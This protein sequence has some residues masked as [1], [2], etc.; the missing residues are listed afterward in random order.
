MAKDNPTSERAPPS[1]SLP[2][3]EARPDLNYVYHLD[4][5]IATH[6]AYLHRRASEDRVIADLK[7]HRPP[8]HNTHNPRREMLLEGGVQYHKALLRWHQKRLK[9]ELRDGLDPDAIDTWPPQAQ[10]YMEQIDP[11]LSGAHDAVAEAVQ[12]T[13]SE[14]VSELQ[15]AADYQ[16]ALE[17]QAAE[18]G[19]APPHGQR[20]L[21][22]HQ[23]LDQEH[24][25][26]LQA[27]ARVQGPV[28]P[29][30]SPESQQDTESESDHEQQ[31]AR[32][33]F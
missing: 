29:E 32:R 15:E 13:G 5:E 3:T 22:S 24:T 14:R 6:E 4:P 31:V 18:W 17:V 20:V 2:T 27:A 33:F 16:Y 8:H 10:T 12:A 11:A 9:R 19:D 7:S 23:A 21:G 1:R 28:E 26:A 30:Q 25:P